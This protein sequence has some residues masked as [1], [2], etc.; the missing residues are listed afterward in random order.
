MGL[1]DGLVKAGLGQV[2]GG[3]SQSGLQGKVIEVLLNQ[4]MGGSDQGGLGGLGNLVGMMSKNGLGDAVNSW[5]GQGQNQQVN[6]DQIVQGLDS[7]F[8]KNIASQLGASETDTAS[9]LGQVLP[10]LIDKLTPQG[11]ADDGLGI[12]DAVSILGNLLK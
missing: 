7:D 11:Q 4:V 8:L 12:D 6:A 10:G 3:G 1:L 5:V 9:E 2:L